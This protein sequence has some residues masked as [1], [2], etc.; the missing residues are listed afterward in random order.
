MNIQGNYSWRKVIR[1]SATFLLGLFLIVSC[2]KK[3]SGLGLNTLDNNALLNSVQMDTFSLVTYTILDDSVITKDPV[4]SVLGSYNDPKFGPMNAGFYTQLRLSGVNPNF[5]DPLTIVIDSLILGLEYSGYYGDLSDQTLE[6]FEL[7]ESISKDS[8]YYAFS[9]LSYNST[10]LVEPGFETFSPDPGGTT[11][12]GEDTVDTQLRIRLKNSLAQS[13][14]DEATSGGTNF[15]S[16]DNFLEFFKGLYVR[17]NNS[18][19]ASGTG[20]IFYFNLNDALSKMTIYYKQDGESKEYDFVINSECIDFNHVE[21][22]YSGKDIQQVISN[23]SEGTD[24]FYAQSFV[25]RAVVSIPGIS[26]LPKN[27]V[28]HRADLNL[29]VQYQTGTKYSPG[30][31]VSVVIRPE[32]DP[33][34]LSSI[35]VFGAFDATKKHFSVDLSAYMQSVISGLTPNTELIFS[36]R[37][38][39]TSADRIIFN[40]QG[41]DNKKQPQLIITY[42]A[43]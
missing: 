4:Y 32:N 37:Y 28:I 15:A 25:S 6:V 34:S 12:I 16:N 31:E 23:P 35:G 5:G 1:L 10:N 7:T 19:Q 17:V 39:V 27:A 9:T 22:D 38:F 41:T 43:Y 21:V 11:V 29:P 20:A 36:P 30:F 2:K 14:I 26:N 13:F 8:V 40:G 24:V 3:E 33:Y 18:A 42:T